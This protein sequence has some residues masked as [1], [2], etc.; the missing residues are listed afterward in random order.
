MGAAVLVTW[1]M[2]LTSY[3]ALIHVHLNVSLKYMA[4]VC[5]LIIN[6]FVTDVAIVC[7]EDI[8]AGCPLVYIYTYICSVCSSRM[9]AMLHMFVMW[10]LYFCSVIYANDMKYRLW[11]MCTVLVTSLDATAS[12]DGVTLVMTWTKIGCQSLTSSCQV[13]TLGYCL[14][15]TAVIA[16]TP[17]SAATHSMAALGSQPAVQQLLTTEG[18]IWYILASFGCSMH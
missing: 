9:R 10:K 18:T 17:S 14:Q 12:N 2:L 15:W 3:V 8:A 6:F 13:I 1:L 11:N 5:N 16:E 4:Y 7:E